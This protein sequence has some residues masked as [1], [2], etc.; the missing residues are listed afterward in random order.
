[1]W[2]RRTLR[3]PTGYKI[4]ALRAFGFC[5]EEDLPKRIKELTTKWGR[6]W[7]KNKKVLAPVSPGAWVKCDD[8]ETWHTDAIGERVRVWWPLDETWYNGV[9]TAFNG[10]K[11]TIKYD[12]DDVVETLN[13]KEEKFRIRAA[14]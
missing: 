8:Y 2:L 1:M 12:A 13:L 10:E 14:P 11:H 7:A 6:W 9:I 5:K 4:E 3:S